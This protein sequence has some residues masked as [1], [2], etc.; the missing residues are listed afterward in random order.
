MAMFTIRILNENRQIAAVSANVLGDR[1]IKLRA[2]ERQLIATISG[3][4]LSNRETRKP[5]IGKPI[6]EAT[7]IEIKRVPNSA[8][9]KWN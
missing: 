1:L 4:R 6:M 8:S 9:L 5:D 2:S 7:G 3:M